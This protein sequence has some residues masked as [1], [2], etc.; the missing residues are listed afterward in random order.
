MEKNVGGSDRLARTVLGP[1]L[2]V[3][4]GAG[5]AGLVPFAPGLLGPALAAAVTAVGA[6]LLVTAAT[7]RCLLYALLGI[8]TYDHGADDAPGSERTA[9]RPGP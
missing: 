2:I 8:G 9:S 5:L 4:G 6:V 7:E 1:V 3:V